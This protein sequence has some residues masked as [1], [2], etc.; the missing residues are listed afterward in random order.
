[1]SSSNSKFD[2][3]DSLR[4]HHGDDEFDYI[5]V[6]GGPSAM[7]ILYAFLEALETKR[8]NSVEFSVCLMEQGNAN[9]QPHD[10]TTED[11]KDWFKASHDPNSNSVK[12]ISTTITGRVLDFPLGIGLGGTSN[13]N[14]CLCTPPLERDFD[15]WP[16]EW[17]QTMFPAVEK[18]QEALT[19]NGVLH[20][21]LNRAGD[22]DVFPFQG[23]R[24]VGMTS[25]IPTIVAKKKQDPTRSWVRKSYYDGLVEPLIRKHP[26]FKLQILKG[27]QVERIVIDDNDDDDADRRMA[28]GVIYS[29][30]TSDGKLVL[31]S[32]RA[33]RRVILAAGAIE[34]PA[35]LLTSGIDFDD[36]GGGVGGGG[37]GAAKTTIARRRRNGP[38][39][40]MVAIV[41]PTGVPPILPS[42][43]AM[44]FRRTRNCDDA[45]T[46]KKK[47][48]I[49][50]FLEGLL[51]Y[52]IMKCL[53]SWTL[54][55]S[56]VGYLL[57]HFTTTALLCLMHPVS[58]GSITIL[59]QPKGSSH[60]NN[61]NNNRGDLLLRSNVHVQVNIGYLEDT[62]DMETLK[63]G[64][65]DWSSSGSYTAAT[66]TTTISI[67]VC[68]RLPLVLIM[69][70]MRTLAAAAAAAAPGWW[71]WILPFVD[72][73]IF[74]FVMLRYFLQQCPVH[75]P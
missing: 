34:S 43:V 41:D 20:Q 58:E 50:T 52:S 65:N 55:Y 35:L 16:K 60:N 61:K 15:S 69:M 14:A 19:K 64:W 45:V 3:D 9:D 33:R 73:L 22:D 44:A 53:L 63:K 48:K 54:R 74:P 13:I 26:H 7:G 71:M 47:K 36:G 32:I 8:T 28:K 12:N 75:Q 67:V 5:I 2:D 59:L 29:S 57:H 1:M 11:P 39:R 38:V 30:T 62:R 46:N 25:P 68:T 42:A 40:R 18:L 17:K 23:T 4:H 6:G 24:F 10:S 21:G 72:I 49:G 70:T 37:G 27:A 31:R 56:P 51:L 66:T